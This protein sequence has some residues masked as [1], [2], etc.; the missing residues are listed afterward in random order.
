M[1]DTRERLLEEVY[2]LRSEIL[3]CAH[4]AALRGQMASLYNIMPPEP[5]IFTRGE[6]LMKLMQVPKDTGS[7]E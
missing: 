2:R 4:C 6:A 1:N 3:N 7:G 5:M